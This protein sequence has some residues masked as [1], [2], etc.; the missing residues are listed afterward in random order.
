MLLITLACK[1]PFKKHFKKIS[2][3]NG[4]IPLDLSLGAAEG[5]KDE[6]PTKN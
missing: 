2:C 3:V 5:N 4:L 6:G 1:F